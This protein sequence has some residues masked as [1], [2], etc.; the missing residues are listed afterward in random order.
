MYWDS[1][2]LPAGYLG[3][4]AGGCWRGREGHQKHLLQV[5]M[6]SLPWKHCVVFLQWWTGAMTDRIKIQELKTEVIKIS[7]GNFKTLFLAT[8]W[9]LNPCSCCPLNEHPWSNHL[10]SF[11]K[12]SNW[13]PNV[14]CPSFQL[15]APHFKIDHSEKGYDM[16]DPCFHAT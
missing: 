6:K 15:S 2:V 1:Q 5:T 11:K 7:V 16:F 9:C 4:G 13:T 10:R 3:M 8:L 14:P 12:N